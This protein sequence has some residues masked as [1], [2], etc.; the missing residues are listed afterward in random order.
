M[1]ISSTIC[2]CEFGIWALGFADATFASPVRPDRAPRHQREPSVSPPRFPQLWK[3]L[4]KSQ[5][6]KELGSKNRDFAGVFVRRKRAEVRP[7]AL[8]A[9]RRDVIAGRIRNGRGE[10]PRIP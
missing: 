10:S 4:W 2:D 3:T 1:R 6:E 5:G 7:T 8:G 9:D